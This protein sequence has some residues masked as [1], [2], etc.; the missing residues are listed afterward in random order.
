[1]GAELG[2]R[3]Q[4]VGRMEEG[5]M[6]DPSKE[7]LGQSR[8]EGHWNDHRQGGMGW[9]GGMEGVDRKGKQASTHHAKEAPEQESWQSVG[10]ELLDFPRQRLI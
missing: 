3:L 6:F 1:M 5:G 9:G 10:L 4:A 8:F 2:R 7:T